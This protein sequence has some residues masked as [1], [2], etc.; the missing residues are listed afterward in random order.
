MQASPCQPDFC[1]TVRIVLSRRRRPFLDL[2]ATRLV[3]CYQLLFPIFGRRA[4]WV[5]LCRC[6]AVRRCELLM[7]WRQKPR[8]LWQTPFQHHLEC[9]I[10]SWAWLRN[11][12]TLGTWHRMH[13]I[14]S[15]PPCT[16][17]LSGSRFHVPRR[18]LSYTRHR[19][20]SILASI[21][22]KVR[23]TDNP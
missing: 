12:K 21:K 2:K 19:R 22:I 18:P 10:Q 1:C 11:G 15:K 4:V 20:T 6:V 17:S 13:D 3:S 5:V 16:S 23:E 9:E 7:R 8:P 14:S